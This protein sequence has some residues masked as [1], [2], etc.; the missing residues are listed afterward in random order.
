MYGYS[1]SQR[2]QFKSTQRIRIFQ[3]LV[4]LLFIATVVLAVLLFNAA[5]FRSEFH[6]STVR[7]ISFEV[8]S[9][10]SQVNSLSRTG[11]SNTTSV[12]GKTR[13]HIYAAKVLVDQHA[14][15]NMER[16]ISAEVFTQLIATLDTFEAN[17]LAGQATL[18]QQTLLVDSLIALDS[19]L[20]ALN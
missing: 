10:L 19:T 2:N 5:A 11:G 15:L 8:D 16:L 1:S 3:W 12:L 20:E 14:A 13:Q 7:N 4:L 9:A 18:E 6:E 17:K